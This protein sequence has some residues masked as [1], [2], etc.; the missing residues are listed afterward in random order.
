MVVV[1]STTLSAGSS[2]PLGMRCIATV[3]QPGEVLESGI[4]SEY[5]LSD[6]PQTAYAMAGNVVLLN[7]TDPET[8][9]A[10]IQIL[11]RMGASIL[12]MAGITGSDGSGWLLEVYGDAHERATV[13]LC[14]SGPGVDGSSRLGSG[15]LLNDCTALP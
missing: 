12:L 8:D 7:A 3:S 6:Y 13:R 4:G 10:E 2:A 11:D 1:A 5:R 14:D 15:T 9:L